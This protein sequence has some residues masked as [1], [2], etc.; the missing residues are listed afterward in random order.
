MDK[1]QLCNNVKNNQT[2]DAKRVNMLGC[3]YDVS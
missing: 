2:Q 3:G 1:L